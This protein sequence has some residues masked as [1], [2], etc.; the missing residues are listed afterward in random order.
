[1]LVK[2]P[3]LLLLSA[4]VVSSPIG[5]VSTR[6][7]VRPETVENA[8]RSKH[9]VRDAVEERGM[10]TVETVTAA[11]WHVPLSGLLNLEH[12]RAKAEGLTKRDEPIRI[13]FHALR[14]PEHG[15]FIVD[16]GVERAV[17]ES[18]KDAVF[19]GLVARLF[20]AEDLE[21]HVTT[22]DWLAGQ[23]EP[24]AGVFLTHLHMDHVLGLPDIPAGTP[25][26]LGAG[27]TSA[28]EFGN[29]FVRPIFNR[30][31]EGHGALRAW[32]FEPD[33]DGDFEGVRD[34][35]GDGSLWAIH[36]PGHTP[37]TTAYL[38]QSEQG[39]VLL[40]GDVSHTAWGWNNGVEPGTFS[41]DQVRS[42]KSLARLRS[43]ADKHPSL[44]VRVG[45]QDL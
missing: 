16:T 35:F 37:G 36:A 28:R 13:Y 18:P 34:V 38:I 42:A 41:H 39:P 21:V 6:H 23:S 31:L 32:S 5:C 10:W 14:H 40:T 22:G 11:D 9:R 1:M 45:H 44:D 4:L 33:P 12:D 7:A 17:V 19:R 24:L 20:D 2:R 8:P 26:Y 43:F 3:V 27:E 29:A 25:I 30:A 15:L